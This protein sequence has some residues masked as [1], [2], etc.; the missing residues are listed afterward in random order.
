MFAHCHRLRG[1]AML[2]P[3]PALFF[4]AAL[5]LGAEGTTDIG[6]RMYDLETKKLRYEGT[7]QRIEAEG[8]V[9]VRTQMSKADGTKVQR[10]VTVYDAQT[11][12]LISF[13]REDFLTGRLE[14]MSKTGGKVVISFKED[15]GEDV[16]TE[17]LD[18][19]D[20]MALTLTIVPLLQRNWKT[21][22]A[23]EEVEIQLLVPSRQDT[24]TFDLEKDSLAKVGG[25]EVTVV[26]MEPDSFFIRV[27]VD[28]LYFYLD[29]AAPHRLL[30]YTGRVSVKDD[31]GDDLD[32]R[33]EYTYSVRE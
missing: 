12:A 22:L 10:E 1:A 33:A 9:T 31:D 7:R 2:L 24:V 23:G 15:R 11:L 6:I 20:N 26:V 25:R 32:L 28:P 14:K 16:E 5:A 21:I 8:K 4:L 13:E 19:E 27:L 29:N 3:L 30:E 18:W 17:E